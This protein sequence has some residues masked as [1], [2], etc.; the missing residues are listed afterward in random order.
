MTNLLDR[1]VINGFLVA[2]RDVTDARRLESQF[3][4]AQ[5]METVGSLAGGVAHDFNNILTTVIGYSDLVLAREDLDPGV[6]VEVE[7]IRSAGD[8]ASRVTR[9]L[10]AFTRQQTATPRLL[11]LEA[12]IGELRRMLPTLAGA[13]IAFEIRSASDTPEVYV[14]PTHV[15]QVILNLVV[16]AR[17]ALSSGGRLII[18]T[19]NYHADGTG[20]DALEP[21][22][23]VRLTVRDS[24]V[25]MPEHVR[26]RALEPFYTTKDPGK[27]TGLG[28][29]TCYGILKRA[30]GGILI[31][32]AVGEGTAVH[33]FWPP[34][35]Q[36]LEPSQSRRLPDGRPKRRTGRILVV[37]D[38]QAVRG[39]T[40]AL[41]KRHGFDVL[42]AVDGTEALGILFD[43][44]QS[45][46]ALDLVLIDIVLPGM[47][48]W[49]LAHEA[50]IRHPQLRVLFMSGYERPPNQGEAVDV[51]K[52]R[53]VKKPFTTAELI[54]AVDDSLA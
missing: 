54:S 14:D 39:V 16:N 52:G 7:E 19:A 49:Q 22:N 2:A 27:G 13:Q 31:E 50:G 18:E 25:G 44:F 15:E 40:A 43:I 32:S 41:L 21:G 36:E 4:Q 11:Q 51:P 33:T 28:L 26:V 8:R 1:P 29:S 30:G 45:G 24:G 42:V 46:E 5:K 53:L 9:Q 35:R 17:D 6:R 3:L 34:A 47:S 10:L 37:D 12:V 38:D 20:A 23:Y 48:G